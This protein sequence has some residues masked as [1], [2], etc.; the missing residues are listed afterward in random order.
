MNKVQIEKILTKEGLIPISKYW[1]MR[2]GFLDI[3]NSTRLFIPLIE[4]RDDTG[5]D[6]KAMVKI[7]YEWKN[8]KEIN[9]GEGGALFRY[10]QFASWKLGLGKTFI[11]EGTLKTR[12][13]CHNPDIVNWPINKLL[14]L[15]NHTP[16]WAS[17]S[18]LMGNKEKAPDDYFLNL[19]KEALKHYGHARKAGLACELRYDETI[20]N[21]AVAFIG[22]LKNSTM[23]YTP[24]QQDEYCFARAFGLID[25]IDGDKRWP[26]LKGHESNR[27]EEMEDMLIKLNSNKEIDS[28]D[29]RV[30][31]SL[32]MLAMFKEQKV[33]FTNPSCV[34]KSW[35]QFWKFLEWAK[36]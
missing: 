27:L 19:S 1:S 11:K 34:S 20:L 15:D 36:N 10:L 33:A 29:H 5:D 16:Q 32:A 26:E 30:I 31:Q 7:S 22:L 3:L 14:E 2:L 28:R 21:Q 18:I 12:P 6:L 17:V 35:P 24:I 23:E 25:K 4:N 9:V 13:V 8:K